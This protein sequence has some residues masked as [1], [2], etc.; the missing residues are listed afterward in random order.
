MPSNF[1]KVSE[2]IVTKTANYTATIGDDVIL[3]DASSGAVTITLYTPIGNFPEQ[4]QTANVGNVR[5]VKTDSSANAVTVATAAGSVF[6][7]TVLAQQYQSQQ[8]LSDGVGAWYGFGMIQ[9]GFQTQVSLSSAQILA[10]HATPVTL[11]PA[12]GAGTVIIVDRVI[13]KMVRTSTQYDSGGAVELRYTNASGAKVT[14]DISASLVTGTAGT[15]YSS[16]AGVTTELTPVANSPIV[17]D[18]ATAAFTT[19]T[20][21]GVATVQFRIVTP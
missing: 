2:Q 12:A 1:G 3:V 13:L 4:T 19:G 6:G 16:V 15:A 5:V 10:L 17:I 7:V 9:N 14:A 8:Y 20:G 18:N 21:T 11:V